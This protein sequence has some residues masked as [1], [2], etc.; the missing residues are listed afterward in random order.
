MAITIEQQK[1]DI[2]NKYKE[3]SSKILV[4]EKRLLR[5][6]RIFSIILIRDVEAYHDFL[7][8]QIQALDMGIPIVKT[9]ITKKQA[10]AGLVKK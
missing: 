5:G 7:K 10:K 2:S 3:L 9:N 4:E 8:Q 6:K 1:I